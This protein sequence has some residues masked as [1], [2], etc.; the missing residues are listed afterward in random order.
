MN[1]DVNFTCRHPNILKMFG[2]FH[3][4]TRVYMILEFAH[5]GELY[6]QLEKQPGKKFDETR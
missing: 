2:Y 3:D 4:D 1:Y 6:K 5:Q